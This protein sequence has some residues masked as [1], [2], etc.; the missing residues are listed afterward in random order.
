MP[1]EIINPSKLHEPPGYSHVAVARGNRLVFIAGQV[2]LDKS[3]SVVGEGDLPAQTRKALENLSIA[4]EEIGAGWDDAVRATVYTTEPTRYEEIG[5]I[6]AE[7]RGEAAPPT[8]VLFGVSSLA[9]PE[10]LIEIDL[11]VSVP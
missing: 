2:A 11:V 7:V 10:L 6:M 4:L 1:R 9:M 8:Q 5:A 3:L